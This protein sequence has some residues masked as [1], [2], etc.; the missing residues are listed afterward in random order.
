MGVRS[1][2]AGR[3]QGSVKKKVKTSGGSALARCQSRAIS[4]SGGLARASAAAAGHTSARVSSRSTLLSNFIVSL[5]LCELEA[6]KLCTLRNLGR[7]HRL[8]APFQGLYRMYS[9]LGA[10]RGS[11]AR[12][13]QLPRTIPSAFYFRPLCRCSEKWMTRTLRTLNLAVINDTK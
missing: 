13:F 11:G 4:C 3:V 2:P 10:A 1:V 12:P 7:R 5:E 9:R 6:V 8:Y